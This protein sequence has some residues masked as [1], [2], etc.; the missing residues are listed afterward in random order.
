[1]AVK[2]HTVFSFIRGHH[3]SKHFWRPITG[4]TLQTERE[5][6]NEH[7]RFAFAVIHDQGIVGYVPR[8]ISKL[9]SSFIDRGGYITVTVTGRRMRCE[10]LQGGLDVPCIM[11]VKDL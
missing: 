10:L 2:T 5:P 3:V 7:D 9:C 1:M 11:E 4:E 8:K 6:N